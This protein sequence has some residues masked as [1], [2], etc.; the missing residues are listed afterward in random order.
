M[1]APAGEWMAVCQQG[2]SVRVAWSLLTPGSTSS[3]GLWEDN[4]PSLAVTCYTEVPN[5]RASAIA[6][7][8]SRRKQPRIEAKEDPTEEEEEEEEGEEEVTTTRTRN[9]RE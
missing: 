1:R 4:D 6:A 7:F 3:P 8:E 5:P 2:R 9:N